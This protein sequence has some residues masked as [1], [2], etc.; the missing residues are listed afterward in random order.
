MRF[1]AAVGQAKDWGTRIRY[2]YGGPWI[3]FSVAAPGLVQIGP[4]EGKLS[5]Y[6][7]QVLGDLW[8]V[9]PKPKQPLKAWLNV[10]ADLTNELYRRKSESTAYES[11]IFCEEQPPGD[12]NGYRR[13]PWLDEPVPAL[14]PPPRPE[15]VV[16][17]NPK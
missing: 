5:L 12:P 4:V 16:N 7:D 10:H 1:E 9:E 13:A 8:E 15:C 17:G 3:G 6:A 11:V 14:A 2:G